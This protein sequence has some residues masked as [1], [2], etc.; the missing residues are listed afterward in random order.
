[1]GREERQQHTI[2]A[3][4]DERRCPPLLQT[5]DVMS[6]SYNRTALKHWTGVSTQL[7]YFP[8]TRPMSMPLGRF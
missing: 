5:H 2:Q 3:L 8:L 7:S 6:F 4:N 1:M